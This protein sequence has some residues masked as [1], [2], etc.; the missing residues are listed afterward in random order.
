MATTAVA[1]PVAQVVRCESKDMQ[2]VFC[3]MD[4]RKGV[5][6]V[7]QLSESAC[8]RETSWGVEG[9]AVWV[10]ENCRAEFARRIE[11]GKAVRRAVRCES[12]GRVEVC[13]VQLRGAP[14]RLLRQQ[15]VLPCREGRSWGYGRNEI[16]VSRGCQGLFEVGAEDGSGFVQTPRK[17]VCESK[18]EQRR[19][20]GV[21]V[22]RRVTL[23]EQLSSAT[24]REGE[25]WGWDAYGIWVDDGCRA[26]F[27]VD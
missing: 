5:Q 25:T 17:V 6:L 26:E 7:R 13:P 24:C 14:V 22:V 19:E 20:C 8:I 18:G 21:S 16:W 1:A 3:P 23:V 11:P 12:R 15:S 4:T 10:S 9:Q 27:S 2:R